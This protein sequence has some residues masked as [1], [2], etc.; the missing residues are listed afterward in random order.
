MGSHLPVHRQ[1]LA[2]LSCSRNGGRA[3]CYGSC[4][5]DTCWGYGSSH[6]LLPAPD[7]PESQEQPVGTPPF[8]QP[9]AEDVQGHQRQVRHQRPL[10]FQLSEMAFEVQRSRVR[11]DLQFHHN[12]SVNRGPKEPP[13]IH[14]T[15]ICNRG[16]KCSTRHPPH[17][18]I[19]PETRGRTCPAP[20]QATRFAWKSTD[21]ESGCLNCFPFLPQSNMYTT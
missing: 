17:P 6:P 4:S 2:A 18:D 13:P 14:W 16:G 19:T 8:H 5:V 7:I 1:G 11:C 21:G 12:P 15:G 9:L 3:C 10:L 20:F